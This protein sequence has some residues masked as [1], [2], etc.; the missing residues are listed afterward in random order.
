MKT[1]LMGAGALLLSQL[2]H[3]GLPDQDPVVKYLRDRFTGAKTATS[4]LLHLGAAWN[5]QYYR[6]ERDN[7]DHDDRGWMF[8]FQEF[9][10]LLQNSGDHRV[11]HFATTDSGLSGNDGSYTSFLR[12]AD[13]GDLIDEFI[14]KRRKNEVAS[15]ADPS[16]GVIYYGICPV[17]KI[18]PAHQ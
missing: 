11:K 12:I 15:V 4:E 13:N 8:I 6:A 10:G 7:F 1:L 2:A 9:D 17:D 18:T 14:S 16:R 5:C 3:A